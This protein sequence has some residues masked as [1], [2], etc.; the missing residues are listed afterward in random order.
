MQ[1]SYPRCYNE[2]ASCDYHSGNKRHSTEDCT[3]LKRRIY[4]LIK[5]EALAFDDEDIPDVNRNPLPDHQRP[6]INAIESDPE[7]LIE[8]DIKVV[9]M[10]IGNSV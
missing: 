8:K 6:K 7:L 1:P 10:P 9:Y 4:D 5:A 2:N 3:A